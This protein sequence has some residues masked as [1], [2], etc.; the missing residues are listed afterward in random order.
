MFNLD[1]PFFV[2]VWRRVVTLITCF[3]W[4]ALEFANGAPFWGILFTGL[5]AMAAWQFHTID[6]SKY[7]KPS[8]EED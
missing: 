4:G 8:D 3:G 6:W 5:G 7:D 2:P 1:S